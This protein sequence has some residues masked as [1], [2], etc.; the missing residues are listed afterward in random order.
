MENT[1]VDQITTILT[2]LMGIFIVILI[3]LIFAYLMIRVKS[4]KENKTSKM[5]SDLKNKNSSTDGKKDVVEPASV[6]DF[7]EFEKIQD[8]MIIQKAKQKYLMVIECQGVNYDLMS[9][10]EKTSVEE[11]FIQFLNT[12]RHPIQ[13]Y[14]QTRTINLEDSIN[15]YKQRIKEI[16]SRLI[17]M[18]QQYAMMQES[19]NYSNQEKQKVLFELTKQTNLYEYGKDIIANT[20]KMSFNKNILTKRYY[21]VVPYIPE[22]INNDVTD[23]E[24]ENIAFS[25]LY[26]RS[27]AIIRTI[28]ACNVSGKILNSQE[29]V[30]VLYMAYNRD[31]AE[32][33]GIDKAL[34]AEY[35]TLYSTSE[36]VF[37][38]KMRAL[39]D[40]IEELAVEKAKIKIQEAKTKIQEETEEKERNMELLINEMAKLILQDNK[41]YVGEEIIDEALNSMGNETKEDKKGGKE[42]VKKE[43]K[44][45]NDSK[46]G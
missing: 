22:T 7:M 38:K 4:N 35:D 15:M 10:I 20:E 23:E 43:R 11:G 27:Q 31:D 24:Y 3:V 12:L 30:E 9:G 44:T 29:L 33:Y 34:K 8:N 46:N 37:N 42:N 5:T 36:D 28:S 26:T 6:F 14:I 16:Q 40:R 13:L 1:Q 18:Q 21:I 25:E 32:I 45:K 19:L 39:D 2:I 41:E 17:K